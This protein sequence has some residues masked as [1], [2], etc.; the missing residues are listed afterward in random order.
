MNNN[1]RP[2]RTR[3]W[4]IVCHDCVLDWAQLLSPRDVKNN[5]VSNKRSLLWTVHV[6]FKRSKM[7]KKVSR[8]F[9]KSIAV[10]TKKF[11]SPHAR[12]KQKQILNCCHGSRNFGKQKVYALTFLKVWTKTTVNSLV[13]RMTYHASISFQNVSDCFDV[14]SKASQMGFIDS[15]LKIDIC[16]STALKAN[17]L[18]DCENLFRQKK[19]DLS[20]FL[21]KHD[22]F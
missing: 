6:W 16:S 1:L 22:E 4:M 13:C 8:T 5:D 17:S 21:W 7:A 10:P 19:F 2:D 11:N 18:I 12:Q 9:G 14:S 3:A 15:Q 20:R